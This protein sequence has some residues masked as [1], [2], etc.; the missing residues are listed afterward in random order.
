M[1]SPRTLAHDAPVP[2]GAKPADGCTDGRADQPTVLYA[3]ATGTPAGPGEQGGGGDRS[4]DSGA[5]P[6]GCAR[7]PN[8]LHPPVCLL[9]PRR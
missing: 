7:R 1:S 2:H 6:N 3:D 5:L 9:L 8:G 4:G